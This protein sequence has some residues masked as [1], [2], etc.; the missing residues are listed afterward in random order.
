MSLAR[1]KRVDIS[2][3][4][5]RAGRVL[6][7]LSPAEEP[8]RS[9]SIRTYLIKAGLWLDCLPFDRKP[10]SSWQRY[11]LVFIHSAEQE[12]T[13]QK[14]LQIREL[15][16]APIVLLT[17]QQAY[18]WSLATI[19]IGVDAVIPLETPEAVIYARC[20]ALLRRWFAQR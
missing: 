11:D 2:R 4:N 12:E 9:A 16:H 5:V 8:L 15:H 17:E 10:T 13:L 19:P 3:K 18:K 14:I 6:W 7:L 20:S 1:C